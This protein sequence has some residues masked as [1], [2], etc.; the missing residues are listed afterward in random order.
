MYEETRIS[1]LSEL[2]NS[3]LRRSS[4]NKADKQEAYSNTIRLLEGSMMSNLRE[5]IL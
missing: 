4:G 3:A 2:L 5:E 1:K